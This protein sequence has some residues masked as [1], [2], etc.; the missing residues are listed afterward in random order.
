M[1]ACPTRAATMACGV[2]MLAVQNDRAGPDLPWWMSAGLSFLPPW[3]ALVAPAAVSLYTALA[4]KGL[5][6][7]SVERVREG[8]D[9]SGMPATSDNPPGWPFN[10]FVP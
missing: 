9:N 1:A 7:S 10:L 8:I 5:V 4:A 2:L 6:G 3:A